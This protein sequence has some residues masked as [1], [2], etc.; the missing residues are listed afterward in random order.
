MAVV[1][2][3]VPNKGL[4]R[5]L[6]QSRK[7]EATVELTSRISQEVAS[8]VGLGA[9][10]VNVRGSTK[11]VDAG[12]PFGQGPLTAKRYLY[13]PGWFLRE[14]RAESGGLRPQ[15][16]LPGGVSGVHLSTNDPA[17][18]L[19]LLEKVGDPALRTRFDALVRKVFGVSAIEYAAAVKRLGV[20]RA[21]E[22][23]K[24][25]PEMFKAEAARFALSGISPSGSK[26]VLIGVALLGLGL[27]LKRRMA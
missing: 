27:A 12:V 15:L 1:S 24:D 6:T 23:A 22:L 21:A 2:F 19:E 8:Y 14:L 10:A 18:V 3:K 16:P 13:E 26:K 5:T 25:N 7:R 11:I 4:I 17:L 9:H 20:E